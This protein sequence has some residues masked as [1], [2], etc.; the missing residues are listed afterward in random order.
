MAMK[1]LALVASLALLAFVAPLHAAQ[2]AADPRPTGA[3][4]L[5]G[6]DGGRPRSPFLSLSS[7]PDTLSSTRGGAQQLFIAFPASEAGKPY[8]V[9]GSASGTSP[10]FVFG[11]ALIP[12]NPDAYL[13]QTLLFPNTPPLTGAGGVLDAFGL[14]TA[15]VTIPPVNDLSLVGL[16]LNHVAVVLEVQGTLVVTSVSNSESLSIV[17]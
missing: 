13:A 5:H 16:T 8:Q 17:L 14:A 11:G 15:T 4:A 10:G 3:G 1:N 9:L 6:D 12:L 2:E 7:F